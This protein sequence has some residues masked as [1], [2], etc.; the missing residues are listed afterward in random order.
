MFE[1]G[2]FG[3][4]F[5]LSILLLGRLRH[6]QKMDY[7]IISNKSIKKYLCKVTKFVVVNPFLTPLTLYLLSLVIV[8]PTGNFAINDDWDFYLHVRYFLNGIYAKN[9]LIDASFILQGFLGMLWAKFFGLSF[10]S[11]RLLTILFTVIF[12]YGFFNIL[13]LFRVNRS[14][15]LFSL[16]LLFFNPLIYISSLTF[17]TE[18]YFLAFFIWSVYFFLLFLRS[19]ETTLTE[20]T[21][22]FSMHYFFI[23]SILGALSLLIRQYG[24]VLFISYFLV[25]IYIFFYKYSIL[26]RH[27]RTKKLLQSLTVLILLYGISLGI[28]LWWPVLPV[29]TTK[30]LADLFIN[31]QD[32][33]DSFGRSL[34]LVIYFS[35]FLLPISIAS[36]LKT[37]SVKKVLFAT[38]VVSLLFKA[39]YSKDIF[40]LGNN[41]YIESLFNRTDFKHDISLFDN[42]PF[43]FMLTV[44]TLVSFS[45]L[46]VVMF[47]QIKNLKVKGLIKGS[48]FEEDILFIL[49]LL[50]M[51]AAAIVSKGTIDRYFLNFF[52][53]LFLTLSLY[54]FP[55][56][57]INTKAFVLFFVFNLSFIILLTID[58]MS[59]Q[60]V[61]WYQAK[62]IQQRENIVTTVYVDGT[63]ARYSHTVRFK[64]PSEVTSSLPLGLNYRCFVQ[65]Y[66]KLSNPDSKNLLLKFLTRTENSRTL[67]KYITNPVKSDIL[68]TPRIRNIDKNL[69]NLIFNQEVKSPLYNWIGKKV[70]VG[71]YC[72]ES[73]K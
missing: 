24:I 41:L 42:I 38:L 54:V 73:S 63:F 48:K 66:S 32:F 50:G 46:F 59:T 67:N 17:M 20:K 10:F 70:F 27:F 36:Y 5:L 18:V 23:S 69:D 22:S 16:L 55:R 33:L 65:K 35:F 37:I 4:F 26:N 30:K 9:Q 45:N 29:S 13:E 21:L 2:S 71:S 39:V 34:Y 7:H 53:V 3:S 12:G 49:L 43:K 61:K 58:F 52:V 15:I 31:P 56:L 68:T 44:L 47:G 51:Y 8:N 25:L 62:L 40:F 11:L 6:D 64:H 19:S 28:L 72:F 60:N 14:F 57:Q 1:K